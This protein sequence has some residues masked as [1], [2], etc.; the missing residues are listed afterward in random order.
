MSVS[1]TGRK[2]PPVSMHPVRDMAS[3]DVYD[4]RGWRP[5]R[6]LTILILDIVVAEA[7]G[8]ALYESQQFLYLHRQLHKFGRSIPSI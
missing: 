3:K 5:T 2:L 1:I 8:Q 4:A 6:P 7:E